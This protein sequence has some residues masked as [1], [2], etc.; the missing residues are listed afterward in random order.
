MG[1]KANPK[2]TIAPKNHMENHIFLSAPILLC[3]AVSI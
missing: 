3:E 2:V 1:K